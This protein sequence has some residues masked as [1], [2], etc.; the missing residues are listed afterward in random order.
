MADG[1]Y[2]RFAHGRCSLPVLAAISDTKPKKHKWPKRECTHEKPAFSSGKLRKKCFDCYPKPEPKARK[3]FTW[4]KTE[5]IACKGCG[6]EFAALGL[7]LYCSAQC[8]KQQTKRTQK[9]KDKARNTPCSQCGLG[10]WSSS[11]DASKALCRDCY[12]KSVGYAP[13]VVRRCL[14]CLATYV[15]KD[16]KVRLGK[17]G[18]WFCS[19]ECSFADRALHG[20]PDGDGTRA[21][22]REYGLQFEPKAAKQTLPSQCIDCSATVGAKSVRCADCNRRRNNRKTAAHQRT[23][24]SVIRTC[25]SCLLT[26]SAIGKAGGRQHCHTAECDDAFKTHQREVRR[27]SKR[28]AGGSNHQSRARRFGGDREPFNPLDVLARDRWRCQLCGVK[29]P[30]SKRGSID[31]NAPEL[32]HIIPLS[33][34]GGHTRANTQC[35]CRRCNGAKGDTA[36]GQLGLGW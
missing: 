33:K 32:D 27:E 14:W 34:G 20:R 1:E 2:M 25:P 17:S 18:G 13:P 9:S 31:A 29:T 30:K 23:L 11:S 24:H 22:W 3:Q 10:C 4:A 35:L 7:N 8:K 5:R 21:A 28:R 6:N 19:R 36:R 16:A 12:R 15:P 26:W